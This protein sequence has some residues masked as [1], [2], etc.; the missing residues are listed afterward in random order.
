LKGTQFNKTEYADEYKNR[1]F[2]QKEITKAIDRFSLAANSTDHFPSLDAKKRLQKL[3]ISHFIYNFFAAG[4]NGIGKSH[5]LHYFENEPKTTRTPVMPLKEEHTKLTAAI[6]RKY[7]EIVLGGV[8]TEFSV[9][10]ENHFKIAARRLVEF[11]KKNRDRFLSG[12]LNFRED[13][14]E[15]M[16][17]SITT[18]LNGTGIN[19][20]TPAWL[21]S[22]TQFN[23]RLPAFLHDRSVMHTQQDSDGVSRSSGYID[24]S[25][26]ID[27]WLPGCMKE[28]GD[29][30]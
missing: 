5:F 4:S 8:R 2:T 20:V 9:K 21:S 13:M 16:I 3:P 18:T 10:D 26:P 11:V 25:R 1:K 7:V 23:L 14:A 15:Y 27:E 6:K 28:E 19:K 12:S 30:E 22:N 17:E 24:F 29:D